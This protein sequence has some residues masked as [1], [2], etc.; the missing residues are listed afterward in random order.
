[1]FRSLSVL[2]ATAVM[3]GCGFVFVHGP[4]EDHA[5]QPYFNCTESNAG[6]I[7]DLVWAGLN[8]GGAIDAQSH[9][10]NYQQGATGIGI[11][12]AVVSTSAA[13]V[14]FNKV[15]KCQAAKRELAQRLLQ[16]QTAVDS[17]RAQAVTVSPTVDTLEV[18]RSLQLVATASAS[19][20]TTI[21]AAAFSWSSSNDAIASVSA[22]GLVQ[23]T[24]PGT[25]II[26]ARTGNV[27]GTA[28]VVVVP[29]R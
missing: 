2:L 20:G 13:I 6:P 10:E 26:A 11:A 8:L 19:N 15:K 29:R 27:V 17:L 23:A 14:G 5:T 28:S 21:T 9:P 18:G 4:P 22:A 24:A 25:V 7:L 3:S 1:M 12:W 16:G